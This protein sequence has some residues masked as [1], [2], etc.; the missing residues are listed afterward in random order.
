MPDPRRFTRWPLIAGGLLI[1]LL[2]APAVSETL[3]AAGQR[4]AWRRDYAVAAPADVAQMIRDGKK[5]VF[6]DVREPEEHAEFHI[7]GAQ[8]I[9]L[10]D[11]AATDP[12]LFA[13]ADLVVPYCLKDFRGFEG[14]KALRNRGVP[15]VGVMEGF[16]ITSWQKAELP[17]A[18]SNNGMGDA[19][20]LADVIAAVK[21]QPG[22]QPSTYPLQGTR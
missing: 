17:T 7:P 12:T 18:G 13:D 4:D 2:I 19:E 5:V 15:N 3:R 8:S 10:R 16:G 21:A 1:A 20:A 11:V 22:N 9:P 14:A 6:V